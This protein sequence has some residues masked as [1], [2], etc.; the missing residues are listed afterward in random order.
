MSGEVTKR[1]WG[2]FTILQDGVGFKVKRLEVLPKQA[3]SLQHHNKR[4]EHWVV[5]SGSGIIINGDKTLKLNHNDSTY[6]KKGTKHRI[7][8]DGDEVL[9]IIE[10]QCGDELIEEDIVR[11]EDRYGRED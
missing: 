5:V 11:Y 4:D 9:V 8:N 10:V 2:Q 1:P 6:I 7:M 3:T